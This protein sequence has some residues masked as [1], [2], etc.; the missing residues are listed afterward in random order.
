MRGLPPQQC[1]YSSPQHQTCTSLKELIRCEKLSDIFIVTRSPY[2]RLKSEFNWQFCDIPQEA[3]PCY[4]AWVV[5]SLQ[6][7]KQ[8]RHY[9]DN[10]F[11]PALDFLD[12]DYPTKIFRVEDGLTAVV[13]LFI[14]PIGSTQYI[15][16]LHQK[17]SLAFAHKSKDLELGSKALEAVNQFYYCDF[18][19]FGYPMEIT[20]GSDMPTTCF[21]TK[22]AEQEE[23]MLANAAIA[24]QWHNET[25]HQL[26][27]KLKVQCIN[28]C[29]P[30]S[31]RSI[32]TSLI[33]I[34]TSTR[35]IRLTQAKHAALTT[36]S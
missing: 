17:N 1:L 6:A 36:I 11:R 32:S 23:E 22:S 28:I 24:K 21:A 5:E 13:E 10:H 33:T 34:I 26:L 29:P 2:D 30:S 18:L 14:Q 25:W 3:R 35:K 8:D 27:S 12:I 7:A 16:L 20:S 4:S 19:A 15:N 31:R 9:V